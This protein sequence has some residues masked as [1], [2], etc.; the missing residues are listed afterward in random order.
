MKYLSIIIPVY[1][2]SEYIVITINSILSSQRVKPEEF[3]ILIVNDGSLDNTSEVVTNIIDNNK[4]FNIKFIDQRNGGVSSARNHGL[5][6]AT[7][8]FVWF[9]DGDDCITSDAL[10]YIISTINRFHEIEVI[11]IGKCIR[12]TTENDDLSLSYH[13]NQHVSMEKSNVVDAYVLADFN[14]NLG[15]TTYIWKR[16]FLVSNRLRYPENLSYNEDILFVI[17]ALCLANHAVLNM[18][19][20]FYLVRK[21]INSVSREKKDLTKYNRMQMSFLMALSLVYEEYEKYHSTWC[22][23]KQMRIFNTISC[24]IA[25]NL[26]LLLF[27]RQNYSYVRHYLNLFKIMSFYP[28]KNTSTPHPILGYCMR[29]EYVFMLFSQVIRLKLFRKIGK[30]K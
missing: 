16:D 25:N 29:H 24:M 13:R 7:G 1:N 10:F 28:I 23:Q 14:L 9:V 15:H 17:R 26:T 5:E 3:E 18:S 22:T 6:N 21:R 20:E 19:Y 27:S 2:V 11:K 8:K 12:N 30:K 4:S